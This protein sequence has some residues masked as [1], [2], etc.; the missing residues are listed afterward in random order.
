[1]NG[2]K[3][4]LAFIIISTSFNF[5]FIVSQDSTHSEDVQWLF[6][7]LG[8]AVIQDSGFGR[9]PALE[10]PFNIIGDLPGSYPLYDGNPLQHDGV[11]I[12]QH[13]VE[14][15]VLFIAIAFCVIP[16]SFVLV[17]GRRSYGASKTQ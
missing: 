17:I 16:L 5:L 3:I 10:S 11:A 12:R 7:E 15:E 1:M 14:G 8:P 9:S 4:V 13:P 6:P 2:K